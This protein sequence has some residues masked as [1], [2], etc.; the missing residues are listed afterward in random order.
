MIER[1]AGLCGICTQ[2]MVPGNDTCVDHDHAT[3][4]ITGLLCRACN[5]GKGQLREDPLLLRAAADYLEQ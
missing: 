1:Q 3:G 5:V 2:P 4:R